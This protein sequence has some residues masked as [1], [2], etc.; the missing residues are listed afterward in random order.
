MFETLL[1]QFAIVQKET[2]LSHVSSFGDM[3]FQKFTI[4]MF[5]GNQSSPPA[6]H[7]Y[8]AVKPYVAEKAVVSVWNARDAT[9]LSAE[10]RYRTTGSEAAKAAWIGEVLTKNIVDYAFPKIASAFDVDLVSDKG[11]STTH[12]TEEHWSCYKQV[13]EGF[14][15][16]P[17]GRLSDY[18]LQYGYAL[19]RACLNNGAAAEPILQV[20]AAECTFAANAC[21]FERC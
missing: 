17:C 20:A 11:F 5:Q 2:N 16:N 6:L 12:L 9:R 14:A 21:S 13:A 19:A 1:Q 4:G 18:S 7:H 8:Q 15:S 10:Y 3:T